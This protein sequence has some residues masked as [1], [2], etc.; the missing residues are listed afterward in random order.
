MSLLSRLFHRVETALVLGAALLSLL[1]YARLPAAFPSQADEAA[2]R[3]RVLEVSQPGEAVLLAPH[4]AERARLFGLG[5]PV[6][7]LSRFATPEDL[8]RWPGLL[9]LSFDALPR[10]ERD[11]TFELLS[12]AGFERTGEIEPFGKLSLAR[13]RNLHPREV[14]FRAS[15]TSERTR[16]IHFKPYRCVALSPKGS[17]PSAIEFS[18]VT[19]G[20]SVELLAGPIGQTNLRHEGRAPLTFRAAI[21]GERVLEWTWAPGDPE[22]KRASIDTSDKGKFGAGPHTLRFEFEGKHAELCFEAEVTR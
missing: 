12:R 16:E 8:K 17:A 11:A 2:V 4:W 6:L 10:A 3:A 9:V 1:F 19:L 15:A 18:D 20:R 22:E 7:N 21:D 13:F 14:T 5:L